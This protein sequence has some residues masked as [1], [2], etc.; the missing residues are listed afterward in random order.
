MW[1]IEEVFL[2]IDLLDNHKE[3]NFSVNLIVFC[4]PH[5]PLGLTHPWHMDPLCY[6]VIHFVADML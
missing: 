2:G 3:C 4:L 5:V 1:T 6:G